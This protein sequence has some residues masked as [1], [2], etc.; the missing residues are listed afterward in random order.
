MTTVAQGIVKTTAIVKQTGLGVAGS[1]GSQLLRRVTSV[2][3][4]DRNTFK[5][6]EINPSQQGT[7]VTFGLKKTQGKISGLLSPA[8]YKLA[9]AAV[10]RKDFV[11]GVSTTAVVT[12]TA[13]ATTGVQGTFTRS[14]GS[15]L[16]DGF[17][18]GDVVRWTGW[19]TTGV[20]NN[21]ANML[22]IALTALVMTVT[23]FDTTVIGP[24][25]AGDS[26]TVAVVGK[27]TMAP[28]TGHTNDYFSV[29]EWYSDVSKS[30]LFVDTKVSQIDIALPA[31]GNATCNMA[32]LGLS[33]TKGVA[34]VLTS[35]TAVTSTAIMHAS[36]GV[37]FANGAALGNV[38]GLSF[39]ITD[40]LAQGDAIVGSNS[41]LDIARG[42]IEVS[43][44]FTA[45][46]TDTVISDL[47][48]SESVLSLVSVLMDNPT[49]GLSDFI[50]FNFGA[51][52]VTSDAP[53]DGQ[54][55]ISRTFAFTAQI[56]AAGG[57]A[58]A[59][60]NTILSIQD[61]AA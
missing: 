47:Y 2:F 13:A 50:G 34:Q 23:R 31:T 39:T 25:A 26:V 14:T 52:K 28:L 57:A 44:S 9:M 45:L 19:A 22:I 53:D 36:N 48:D 42:I 20:P 27:K 18:I 8:T 58:L 3:T 24:K 40:N 41:P 32:F 15:Y 54:K 59:N 51:I 16:T 21:N 10:L 43:G 4:A 5:S 56:N 11:A 55:T 46:F 1:A 60:D 29:E 61:S 35:P 12:I 38:T 49:V 30:E 37:L 17:K 33:R 6:T 7:G